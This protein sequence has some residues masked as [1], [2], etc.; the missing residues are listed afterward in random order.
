MYAA[1]T[2]TFK[3]GAARIQADFGSPAVINSMITVARYHSA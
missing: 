2:D 3:V 1:E